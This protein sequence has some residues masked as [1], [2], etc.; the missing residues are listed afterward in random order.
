MSSSTRY[1]VVPIRSDP[2][3]SLSLTSAAPT[4][5]SAPA[6]AYHHSF[7]RSRTI[8]FLRL[9]LL[10]IFS[11]PPG[12]DE[13]LSSRCRKRS[14]IALR[15]AL[16]RGSNKPRSEVLEGQTMPLIQDDFFSLAI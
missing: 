2:I 4:P 7:L 16:F 5:A 10:L 8:R 1:V 13:R 9:Q 14:S 15:L 11:S 6:P 12:P 3:R